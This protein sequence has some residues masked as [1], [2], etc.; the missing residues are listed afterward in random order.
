M[1][2]PAEQDA[3]EARVTLYVGLSISGYLRDNPPPEESDFVTRLVG[4][5]D[6]LERSGAHD[7]KN[8]G[9][10]Q[11]SPPAPQEPA[12][13]VTQTLDRLAEAYAHVAEGFRL[14]LLVPELPTVE[15]DDLMYCFT[16]ALRVARKKPPFGDA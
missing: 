3:W 4:I 1:A 12:E 11:L 10:P 2:A 16:V 14:A 9:I 8:L 15:R 6:V 7:V 13:G 5:A